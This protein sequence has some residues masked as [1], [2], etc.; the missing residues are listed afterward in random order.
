MFDFFN[1]K[2]KSVFDNPDYIKEFESLDLDEKRKVFLNVV[3]C[4]HP[5][6]GK[7]WLREKHWL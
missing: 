7:K 5:D 6:D 4:V 2:K 3:L 1:K